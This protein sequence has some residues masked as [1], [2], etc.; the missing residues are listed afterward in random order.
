LE[1][2]RAA[3][4]HMYSF[5]LT[6]LPRLFARQAA[7]Y[8]GAPPPELRLLP[9]MV[10]AILAPLGLFW[11]AFTTYKSVHWIVPI[12]ASVPFGA[13]SVYIFTSSWT[14]LVV[15][16]RPWA[17][18]VMAGN[19][20]MRSCFAAGFPLFAGQMYATLGTVGSTALLG[21]LCTIA[22]PLP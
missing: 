15:L 2:V 20:F 21:G 16:Y 14:Y 8:K 3:A 4:M 17:A 13:G 7:K 18:S 11:L 1:S 6:L 5:V 19:S 9:G 10:G 22:A 12:I